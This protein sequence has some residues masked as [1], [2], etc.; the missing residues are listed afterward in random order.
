M[1]REDY[2]VTHPP[3][4]KEQLEEIGTRRHSDDARLLLREIE[5]LRVL[6]IH[7]LELVDKIEAGQV[8]SD[9]MLFGNGIRS[10]SEGRLPSG[11]CYGSDPR[12]EK[13]NKPG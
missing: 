9:L 4:T 12:E 13:R 8:T 6:E 5:R 10:I 2:P 11:M 3:L 7:A 1:A